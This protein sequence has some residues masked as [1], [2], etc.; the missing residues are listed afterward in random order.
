MNEV[1]G[2]GRNGK[3]S[4]IAHL[5]AAAKRRWAVLGVG[6]VILVALIIIAGMTRT[7]GARKN[8]YIVITSRALAGV[9]ALLLIRIVM[10]SQEDGVPVFLIECAA[11]TGPLAD[12]LGAID[13]R[14]D[15]VP[16]SDVVAFIR[17]QRY[18]PKDGV[19]VVVAVGSRRELVEAAGA[20][21]ADGRAG[22]LPA[23]LLLGEAAIRELEQSPGVEVPAEIALAVRTT[24]GNEDE[25]IAAIKSVGDALEKAAGRRPDYALLD[26]DEGLIFGKIGRVAGIEAFFGGDGLNRYGDAGSRI[27]LSNMNDILA[28]G[29]RQAARLSVYTTMYRGN[30]LQYPVWVWLGKMSRRPEKRV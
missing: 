16:L 1:A 18:V 14:Y 2:E 29:S 20:L 6:L 22:R 4:I 5:T 10:L 27:R 24:G 11:W 26:G 8:P 15:V 30:Y 21:G 9:G 7:P 19:A 12:A 13:R 28:A 23:T 3:D 17:D 25:V